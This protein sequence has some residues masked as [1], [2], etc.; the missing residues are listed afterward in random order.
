MPV[1]LTNDFPPSVGGIQ[2]YMD[3]LAH[4]L[5]DIGCAVCAVAPGPG[6]D[7]AAPFSV[8]RFRATGRFGRLIEM[9]RA[10]SRARRRCGDGV[11]IASSWN[12]AGMVGIHG[13]STDGIVAIFANGSEI[14]R[15]DTALRRS[16]MR[17]TFE[18]ADVVFSVSRYTSAQ[19]DLAGIKKQ[20]VLINGGVDPWTRRRSPSA[21]PTI[22]S[23]G[24]L[25]RRKGFDRVIAA[26]ATLRRF[27]PDVVYEIV[28]DGPDRAY[29][30]QIA[31]CCGVDDRVRFLGCVDDTALRAAYERAWCFALPVRR[32]GYDVEGFGL[33]YLEAAVVGVPSLGGRD[34]GAE[35]AIVH[36]R[37][38]LLVDGNDVHEI[39][40]AL[41]LLLRD[42]DFAA[43]LGDA[44]RVRALAAFPWRHVAETVAQSLGLPHATSRTDRR[45]GFPAAS[46]PRS[47]STGR[48]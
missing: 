47:L 43:L 12:P 6:D 33:V 20:P 21:R 14:V 23:V 48:R 15:Q 46:A 39:G 42:R 5:G 7:S 26:L 38:G 37:T 8:D 19:L 31:T 17:S 45:A 22:L 27:H 35:D 16:L 1:L 25:V 9:D 32:D 36:G 2:R 3:R 18:R 34:S 29:L 11:T 10:L 40:D 4:A 24:R 13:R 30:E 28:G 44:A 41:D